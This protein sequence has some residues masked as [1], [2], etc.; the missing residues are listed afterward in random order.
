MNDY[1]KGFEAYKKY[2]SLYN[3]NNVPDNFCNNYVNYL[4]TK[5]LE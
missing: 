3:K 1:E 5:C 2:E 4:I